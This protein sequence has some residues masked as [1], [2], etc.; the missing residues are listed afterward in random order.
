MIMTSIGMTEFL[1]LWQAAGI[2]SAMPNDC[3]EKLSDSPRKIPL[4]QTGIGHD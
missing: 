2:P 1:A 4:S 3:V